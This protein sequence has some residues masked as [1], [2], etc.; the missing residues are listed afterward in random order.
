MNVVI[1]SRAK[2]DS[3]LVLI[4]AVAGAVALSASTRVV[5]LER[6]KEETLES[7]PS[8]DQG[9]ARGAPCSARLESEQT[10]AVR[11]DEA[12]T[13][14]LQRARSEL[15]A[16][17]LQRETLQKD[18]QAVEKEL[19]SR[20]A[21]PPYEYSLSREQWRE[22]AASGRIK[23]RVPCPMPAGRTIEGPILDQLG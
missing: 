23:Y 9:M 12:G 18:L 17:R 20:E 21:P 14:E 16:L 10:V 11:A 22:L 7:S 1:P 3:V 15:Q 2:R 19:R 6:K 4:G 5:S 8:A 13:K